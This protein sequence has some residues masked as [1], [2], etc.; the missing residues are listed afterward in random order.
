M[1]EN[2]ERKITK[3]MLNDSY[4]GKG[5]YIYD[6]GNKYVGEIKDGVFDGK[7]VYTIVN[8]PVITGDFINGLV[9]G[10]AVMDFLDGEKYEG[11]WVKNK[12]E[13]EG[14]YSW[15]NGNKYVGEWKNGQQNGKGTF[16]WK[17]GA[18]YVG[19]YKDDERNGFGTYVS[20]SGNKYEGEFKNGNFNGKGTYTWTDGNKYE[21]DWADDKQNGKGTYTWKSGDKY[22]GEWK[23]NLHN[24]QGV[25]TDVKKNKYRNISSIYLKSI[26][27]ANKILEH[28]NIKIDYNF[29]LNLL[30]DSD[31]E[32]DLLESMSK[33][34]E[35]YNSSIL[36]KSIALHSNTPESIISNLLEDDYRWVREAAASH[37]KINKQTIQELIKTGDRYILKGLL[38]NPNTD[39]KDKE[40]I[41]ELISD[42]NTYPI[43]YDSYS[44]KT[45]GYG[46]IEDVAGSVDIDSLVTAIMSGEDSWSS[47]IYSDFYSYDDCHHNFLPTSLV[48][49]VVFPDGSEETIQVDGEY[50]YP[51]AEIGE[52][53][54]GDPN[55]LFFHTAQSYEEGNWEYESFE[56]EY[57]FKEEYLKA[58]YEDE[59]FEEGLIKCYEY[60]NPENDD[61]IDSLEGNFVDGRGSSGVDI[62]LY[63]NTKEGVV[64]CDDLC[65]IRNDMQEEGKNTE[66]EDSVKEFIK[67]RY[68]L[69]I[70]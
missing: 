34:K 25:Y 38:V 53:H 20:S 59:A 30:Q 36:R 65:D 10:Y 1:S 42:Q 26:E 8:G 48:D 33:D 19:E 52:E 56:L 4:T 62:E 2:L 23:N 51:L 3:E 54:V 43:E 63:V 27:L 31:V 14:T 39:K 12:K 68:N 64:V 45:Y 28:S 37:S 69:S 50:N 11:Q 60:E 47:Y 21:G 22:E 15:A 18:K 58:I 35:N 55:D 6:N 5:T 16:T 7:G 44:I 40:K 49:T 67:L 9:E 32:V 66:D 13:G 17:S 29:K 61:Y 46:I 41:N 57:E 24:A 70:E